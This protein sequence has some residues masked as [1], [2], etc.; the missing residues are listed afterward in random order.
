MVV[1]MMLVCGKRLGGAAAQASAAAES[2]RRNVEDVFFFN[3]DVKNSWRG[4]AFLLRPPLA[5]LQGLAKKGRPA[6]TCRRLRL[7]K[8]SDAEGWQDEVKSVQ[9]RIGRKPRDRREVQRGAATRRRA[10]IA[11]WLRCSP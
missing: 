5:R 4:P 7:V 6:T 2:G 8:V 3:A 11:C 1:V 9:K 10:S